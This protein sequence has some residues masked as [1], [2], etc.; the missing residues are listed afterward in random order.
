MHAPGWG[1]VHP[2][3]EGKELELGDQPTEPRILPPTPGG[4][5]HVVFTMLAFLCPPPP[6]NGGLLGALAKVVSWD[7]DDNLFT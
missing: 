6:L 7:R 2:A 1:E 5:C 3:L 4:C